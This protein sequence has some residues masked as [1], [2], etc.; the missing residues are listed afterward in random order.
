VGGVTMDYK[1]VEQ[2]IKAL[3][4]S[5]VNEL[6]IE[7]NEIKIKMSKNSTRVV[8]NEATVDTS[9][10]VEVQNASVAPVPH[11]NTVESKPVEIKEEVTE[12]NLYIVK[13]PMVGTFYSAPSENVDAFVKVGDKVGKGTVLCIVEAMKL[14]NE[15]ECE[16]EGS[17]VEVLTKNGEMVEFGQP[18]FKIKL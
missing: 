3:S 1:A 12:E 4:D 11:N 6:E 18:L 15:I 2:L 9:N 8:L 10:Y 13:S 16:V 5:T 17:I 14:M 7:T